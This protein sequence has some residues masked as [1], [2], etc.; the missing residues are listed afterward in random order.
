MDVCDGGESA[1]R[2]LTIGPQAIAAI[3]RANP[4]LKLDVHVVA[5]KPGHLIKPLGAAGA[6]RL[7]VQY[8]CLKKATKD[9]GGSDVAL[10]GLVKAFAMAVNDAGMKFGLSI[11]PDTPVEEVV[12]L[13]RDLLNENLIEFLD[14][15]AV[16]PGKGGQEFDQ[17]ALGKLQYARKMLPAL[18][19]LGIDGGV[20]HR[21]GTAKAALDSGANVLIAGSAIFTKDRVVGENDAEVRSNID[22]MVEIVLNS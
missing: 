6:E 8:E 10:Y 15:L 20:S 13:V 12:E 2:E 3:K 16:K 18:P 17:R 11:A 22:A 1:Q 7:T 19:F 9:D 14:I 5:S 21:H 4:D